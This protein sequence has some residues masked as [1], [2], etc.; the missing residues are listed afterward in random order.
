MNTNNIEITPDAELE[1]NDEMDPELLKKIYESQMKKIDAHDF[2]I[3]NKKSESKL[4]IKVCK[5]KPKNILS[6]SDFTKKVDEEVKK[7][8]PK[9]FISKRADE[10]RKEMGLDEEPEAKRSFNPRKQPYNFVFN[11]NYD[12]TELDITNVEDFPDL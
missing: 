2:L 10:R 1:E 6:L 5:N 3:T 9:K 12:I 8:I 4:K 7:S 11:K